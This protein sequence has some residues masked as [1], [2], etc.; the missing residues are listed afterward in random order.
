MRTYA[1]GHRINVHMYASNDIRT[2]TGTV[3]EEETAIVKSEGGGTVRRED[4]CKNLITAMEG[5]EIS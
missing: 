3:E 5:C 2:I 1:H 4:E